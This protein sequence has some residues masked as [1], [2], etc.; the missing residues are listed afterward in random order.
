VA[1]AGAQLN[2]NGYRAAYNQLWI[3]CPETTTMTDKVLIANYLVFASKSHG[4][5]HITGSWGLEGE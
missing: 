1:E 5:Q 2:A 3:S 4:S